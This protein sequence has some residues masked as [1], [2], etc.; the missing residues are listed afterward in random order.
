MLLKGKS[1][2]PNTTLVG[3]RVASQLQPYPNR[4]VIVRF[5]QFAAM[6]ITDD[7]TDRAIFGS[8]IPR[9][10]LRLTWEIR[11]SPVHADAGWL[12]KMCVR[13]AEPGAAFLDDRGWGAFHGRG[14]G[15][16]R[17]RRGV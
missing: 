10:T 7:F 5:Q 8:S 15:H 1:L 11:Y 14:R 12:L 17:R 6:A 4:T 9:F 2:Y 3:Q 13:D 16:Y